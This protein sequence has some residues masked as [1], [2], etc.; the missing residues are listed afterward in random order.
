MRFKRLKPEDRDL[1]RELFHV[2]AEVFGQECEALSDGY[3]NRLLAR[4]DFWAIA[5]LADDQIVGGLTAH[6]LPMTTAESSEVFL[7]DIAV[8]RNHQRTGVGRR[9]VDELQE[10][11]AASGIKLVFVAAD[12]EDVHALDFYR[13]L[14]GTAS[15]VTIFTFK[16]RAY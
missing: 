1:A 10:Q 3:V 11:A 16:H 7:Y 12:H 13:A 5:A 14:G 15:P 9:L 6:T 4:E 2:L 8:R